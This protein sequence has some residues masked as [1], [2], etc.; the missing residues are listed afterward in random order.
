MGQKGFCLCQR[1][2]AVDCRLEGFHG[3]L[4]HGDG[5][6]LGVGVMTSFFSEIFEFSGGGSRGGFGN[7]RYHRLLT[8]CSKQISGTK[9][10]TPDEYALT[11]MYLRAVASLIPLLAVDGGVKTEETAGSKLGTECAGSKRKDRQ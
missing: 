7:G 4:F 11:F 9:F 2:A 3:S 8:V 10:V 5:K 1:P 6:R